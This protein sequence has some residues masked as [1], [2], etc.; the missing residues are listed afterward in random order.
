MSSRRVLFALSFAVLAGCNC[1]PSTPPPDGGTACTAATDCP[2]TGNECLE[3]ACVSG[4]CTTKPV[5]VGTLVTAQA[6]GDCKRNQCDGVGGVVS[7]NDPTDV[8]DDANDCTVD[9][10]VSG[11]PSHAAAT[12]GTSCGAADAGAAMV[13]NGQ[14]QCVGCVTGADC[15]GEDTECRT[16]TC[17]AGVCGVDFAGQGTVSATQTAGDC[18][19]AECDGLG[20]LVQVALAT[21]VPDDSN[22][23]TDDVCTG[24]TP[25]NVPT[26]AG[27][28]CADG[29]V[30]CD[31]AGAC[32]ACNQPSDCPG[33]DGACATRTCTNH[34]CGMSLPPANTP[35]AMQTAGDCRTAVCDGNGH[36]T[37]TNDDTDLPVDNN[38]CTSDVCTAGAPSNPPL[39]AGSTCGTNLVCNATGSCVGC[40]TAADCPGTST[41][42]R[43]ITCT[44]N[45]CG[46]DFIAQGTPLGAQTT[47]DCQQA[48]CDGLGNPTS[49]ALDTDLPDDGNECTQDVC[50]AGVA[51]HPFTPSGSACTLNGA[52]CDGA[53][54][55]VE[56]LDA[57][58]CTASTDCRMF[59]CPSGTCQE[60]LV[61]A[62]TVVSSQVAGDCLTAV[63]DG[64]GG[65]T[66]QVNDGDLPDDNNQ[67]TQD[68]CT[69]GVPSNANANAGTACAQGSGTLC[70]GAGACV[71]CLA[72][73]DCG[74]NTECLAYQCTSGACGTTFTPAGTALL[75]QTTGDCLTAVCN[76]AGAV[77]AVA[78]DTDLPVD[79]NE[80]TDDVCTNG[81][82]SNPATSAGAA[83]T[84]GGSTCDGLGACVQC[85][86]AS[87][88]GADSEC[89]TF[90]CTTG[91]CGA[92]YTNAGT[93][94]TA[95]VSG[96]CLTATCNG[97]GGVANVAN[98][99]DLPVD[100]LECTN[101]V[102][103]AGVASNPPLPA[104]TA[105]SQGGTQCDGAGVCVG[106]NTAADCGANTECLSYTCTAGV[107]G[108]T[109][110]PA[111]TAVS[112]QT[113]GD[114]QKNECDGSG[115]T[116]AVADDADVPVDATV[117]TNDVCTAG[118]PSN[119]AVAAG[120][121][122]SEGAG[123]T[124]DGAGACVQC[125]TGSD[126][127]SGVCTANVCADP[128]CTDTVKNGAETDAD[129]GGGTCPAC[130][131]TKACLVNADCQTGECTTNVCASPHVLSFSPADGATN[132]A[133]SSTITVTFSTAMNPTTLTVQANAGNC[134]GSLQLSADNFTTCL[135]LTG[136]TPSGATLT[137]TPAGGFAANTHYQLRVTAS[138]QD[139]FGNAVLPF[140]QLT[141]FF[142]AP[143]TSTACGVVISQVYGGGGSSGAPWQTDFIELKN[144][145]TTSVSLGGWSLQYAS[146]G[147]TS[148]TRFNLPAFT[149]PPGAYFLVQA[150]GSTANG[151]PLP[152]PDATSTLNLSGSAGKLALVSN[153]TTL[154]G[155]C[156]TL[157]VVD[158]VGFGSAANCFEGAA[159]TPTLTSGT[160]ALRV[161]SSCADTNSNAA[162]F[163]PAAPLPRN[164]STASFS[165]SVCGVQNET[166]AV[167]E[168]DY[169]NL[170][171]PS[172]FTVAAGAAT[173]VLFGQLYE[174][175]VTEAAGAAAN[176]L[177]QVGWA[178]DG[179]DPRTQ[180]GW[181]F[182]PASFNVQV[183]NNDEYQASFTA[184]PWPGVYRYTFRFSVD[185]GATWTYGDFDGAGSNFGLTFD[186]AQ[187]GTMTVQ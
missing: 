10:C 22:A 138:A 160:A 56:C 7:T 132:V 164:T 32:V 68:T 79:G 129:C 185:S 41:D 83:C 150:S 4:A 159:P 162:D 30:V 166:D 170:Q 163:V 96:D 180:C 17:V 6:A 21:D 130:A 109:F 156:P 47:G 80:C 88:C 69:A 182:V 95:Q 134:S 3:R 144:L 60:T 120:T 71:E 20:A 127:A 5:P 117:C 103:A 149:L 72:A 35:L 9:T 40:N 11:T 178:L 100:G 94:L 107:C 183:G 104:G 141:G 63:C 61:N 26:T 84:Q 58:D 39:S 87:D 153:T 18:Q 158:F 57:S 105:C 151:V 118:V 148:W 137:A 108:T 34:V 81:V 67:C 59:A 116:V 12:S 25:S 31:G 53:G 176:V 49:V 86:Y 155:S 161:A 112:A 113:A 38:P 76:G 15:A 46:A 52:M 70:D 123:I 66:T 179:V 115:A 187:L 174:A 102:C 97:A 157:N 124:C 36:V 122:C 43:T 135:G 126:C 93:V 8:E 114:C 133:T 78:A 74:T 111:G 14:G 19:Q 143:A 169:C 62:G 131:P 37:T 147:G 73:N 85:L 92:T 77:T 142:T 54:T 75:A 168:A 99:G 91:T 175:G 65:F 125:L 110:T 16:R 64:L 101:D 13:C 48:V 55:C 140:T 1:S 146:S 173:P 44:N 28:T 152:T 50:T 106:C 121:A 45:V 89:A 27:S 82:A 51:S 172:S 33:E 23:C 167:N 184:P 29:G 128:T 145:G 119:P 2:A 136:L 24:T 177:A 165:C 139:T 181:Q 98:D 90:S 154:T 171:F 42:C 186:L